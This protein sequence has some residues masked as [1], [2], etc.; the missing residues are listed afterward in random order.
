MRRLIDQNFQPL[1]QPADVAPK[2]VESAVHR[3]THRVIVP[4]ILYLGTPVV[5]ISTTN[6]DGTF[7]LAPMSS[8]WWLHQSCMLGMG[9]RSKTVENLHRERQCVLSV[10]SED[11]VKNVDRLALTTGKYPVPAY[12][13][14][15]GFQHVIDKFEY[16][17][18][19][20]VSSEM[21][22]PPRVEECPIQLEAIVENFHCFSN[23]DD[24]LEAIEVRIIRVYVDESILNENKRHH[25]DSDKWKPLIMSFCEFY[26]LGDKLNP[27]RLAKVF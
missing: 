15:M 19:T 8:A 22:R 7:N 24:H 4:K 3:L 1:S 10:P 18:L 23:P 20:P 25:I 14:N 27:S 26:G 5:L 6:E 13:S 9:T 17:G 21:V 12:K 11:L 2:E 16:V